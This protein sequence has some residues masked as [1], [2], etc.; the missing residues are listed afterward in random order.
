MQIKGNKKNKKENN[1]A[2]IERKRNYMKD[3]S[4]LPQ[5]TYFNLNFKNPFCN[6]NFEKCRTTG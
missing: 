5:H 6:P 2:E 3:D 1:S 4:S